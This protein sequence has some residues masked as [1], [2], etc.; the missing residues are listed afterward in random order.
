MKCRHALALRSSFFFA[1]AALL[2]GCSNPAAHWVK[3]SMTETERSADYDECRSEMRAAT[4]HD[5][6]VDTDITASRGQDWKRFGQYNNEESQLTSSDAEYSNHV[7]FTCMTG[8]GYHP[9]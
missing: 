8:K 4:A 2:A 6:A 3:G 7:L 5:Y 1:V 9:R